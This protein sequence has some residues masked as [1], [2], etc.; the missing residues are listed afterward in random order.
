VSPYRVPGKVAKEIE[1][2][3]KR[4]FFAQLL[5]TGCHACRFV[6]GY[7]G[8]RSDYTCIV[9]RGHYVFEH[10]EAAGQVIAS[11]YVCEICSSTWGKVV[12]S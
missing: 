2:P 3:K 7:D 10:D 9:S 5:G 11:Y 6:V 4:G 12:R 1:I 8:P